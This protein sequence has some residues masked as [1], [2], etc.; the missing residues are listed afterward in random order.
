MKPYCDI[1]WDQ[2]LNDTPFQWYLRNQAAGHS[3][4]TLDE[5]FEEDDKL[6]S[7]LDALFIGL[8]SGGQAD[9]QYN[10]DDT[11]MVFVLA[12]LALRL[13]SNALLQ[14][15]VD[16]VTSSEGEEQ[17]EKAEELFLALQWQSP[18][19]SQIRFLLTQKHPYIS[20]AAIAAFPV[21][22]EASVLEQWLTYQDKPIVLRLLEFIGCQTLKQYRDYVSHFFNAE[23]DDIRFKAACTALLLG[24]KTALD[25]IKPFAQSNN[26]KLRDALLWLFCF[27]EKQHIPIFVENVLAMDWSPRVQALCIAY[28]GL[29]D[30]IPRLFPLLNQVDVAQ[31]AG[32]AFSLIT[33]IN[34]VD[35]DFDDIEPDGDEPS[36]AQKQ[37]MDDQYCDYEE[38]LPWPHAE[39]IEQ[40]WQLNNHKFDSSHQYFS[41]QTIKQDNLHCILKNGYQIE[42]RIAALH[43]VALGQ[44]YFLTHS[45]VSL[46]QTQLLAMVNMTKEAMT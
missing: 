19:D 18:S 42:R 6:E 1:I 31:V 16:N 46:Q 12:V 44:P 10:L 5:L 7:H 38:D 33:G 14:Q 22:I 25:V 21:A 40:W 24:D 45:K 26:A 35:D 11:G 13:D 28:S 37:Q 32:E 3:T 23:D 17:V 9:D 36:A 15:C 4:Y 43:L 30:Y 41:G 20:Q 2:L 8:K 27:S 39:K 34:L 29:T